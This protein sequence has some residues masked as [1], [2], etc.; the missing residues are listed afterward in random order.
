MGNN[1]ETSETK[2]HKAKPRKMDLQFFPMSFHGSF[3]FLLS[4]DAYHALILDHL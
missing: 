4:Q 1:R 2:E 3:S